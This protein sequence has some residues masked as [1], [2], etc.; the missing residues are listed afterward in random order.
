MLAHA[1]KTQQHDPCSPQWIGSSD[2]ELSGD[3]AAE[4]DRFRQALQSSGI[5]LTK[6]D[7]ELQWIGGDA[8]GIIT[9]KNVYLAICA[10]QNLLIDFWL[11]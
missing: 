11:A 3:L 1:W 10:T 6:N 2:L 9:S 5:T 4:W 7:D 8:S